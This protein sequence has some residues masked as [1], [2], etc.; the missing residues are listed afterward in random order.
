MPNYRTAAEALDAELCQSVS[1]V[2]P[3][4]HNRRGKA[5]RPP[6]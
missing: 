5:S 3:L 2:A 4:D 1:N 6:P